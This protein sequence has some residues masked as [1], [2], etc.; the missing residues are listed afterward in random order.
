M[1]FR[2]EV[3]QKKFTSNLTVMQRVQNKYSKLASAYIAWIEATNVKE[4]V[5]RIQIYYVVHT[6]QIHLRLLEGL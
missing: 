3:R 4:C 6:I 1:E 5:P 2:I